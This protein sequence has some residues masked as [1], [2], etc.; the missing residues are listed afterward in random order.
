MSTTERTATVMLTDL[1]GSTGHLFRL[2]QEAAEAQRLEHFGLLRDAIERYGGEELRSTGDGLLVVFGHP[3]NA[4]ATA[5]EIQRALRERN[6][7]P[8]TDAFD[9]RVGLHMGTLVRDEDEWLGTAVRVAD[10][11][12]NSADG[13]GI[14][15]SELVS[16]ICPPPVDSI[17]A[18]QLAVDGVADVVAARD[19]EWAAVE[20]APAPAVAPWL[21]FVV[22]LAHGDQATPELESRVRTELTRTVSR[23]GGD[24]VLAVKA[25]NGAGV[26]VTLS[27]AVAAVG[28]AAMLQR[29]VE[30]LNRDLAPELRFDLSVGVDA[31]EP[32]ER[33]GEYFGEPLVLATRL[34]QSAAPGAIH[35]VRARRSPDRRR[36]SPRCHRDRP[37]AARWAHAQGRAGAARG[38]RGDLAERRR[39]PRT[40]PA[41]ARDVRRRALPR[42]R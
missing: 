13:S 29:S 28:V 8:D 21:F 19:L 15:V 31:G 7:R 11:L 41:G 3:S 17:D 35:R 1:V 32:T 18:G 16:Q 9:V 23:H 42:A 39:P 22:A 12:C 30:R 6:A 37:A 38:G 34:S 27:S 36:G 24:S 14:R 2:G 5:I 4:Y 26:Q 10:T 20:S 40:A 25:I 33:E